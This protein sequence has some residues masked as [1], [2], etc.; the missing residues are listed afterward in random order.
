MHGGDP[1]SSLAGPGLSLHPSAPTSSRR[2]PGINLQETRELYLSCAPRFFS[3]RSKYQPWRFWGSSWGLRGC[4]LPLLPGL[5]LCPG[6]STCLFGGGGTSEGRD[7]LQLELPV[8]TIKNPIDEGARPREGP[9]RGCWTTTHP[10]KSLGILRSPRLSYWQ[11][12]PHTPKP[13]TSPNS[14]PSVPHTHN[15]PLTCPQTSHILKSPHP[16][17]LT[18]TNP[19]HPQIPSHPQTSQFPS[20]VLHSGITLGVLGGPYGMQRM[21]AELSSCKA[22]TLPLWCHTGS[23][24]CI[25]CLL[26]VIGDPSHSPDLL[27]TFYLFYFPV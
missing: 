4:K 22:S 16:R 21:E 25:Y 2:A 7:R 13:V 19:S 8:P 11:R 18:P 3:P 14:A 23:S 12:K 24:L 27:V 17:P 20:K 15:K 9:A 6:D 26:S 5:G 10:P 1:E